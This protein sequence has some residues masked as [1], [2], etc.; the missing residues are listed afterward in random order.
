MKPR[1][2]MSI[3]SIFITTYRTFITQLPGRFL[4]LTLLS[5]MPALISPARVY[6]ESQIFNQASA[7]GE[8]TEILQCFALFILVQILYVFVYPLFRSNINYFGSEFETVL[9]NRMNQKTARIP[10]EDYETSALHK[11]ME[12]ASSGSR[13][14]RFMVMVM[15]SEILL[16]LFQFLSISG[17]LFSFHPSLALLSILSILPEIFARILNSRLRFALLDRTAPISRRKKYF[18][19]ILSAPGTLKENRILQNAGFFFGKWDSEREE[20]NREQER[21]VRKNTGISLLN[22][23]FNLVTVIL[24][25]ALI[26]WLILSDQISIGQ[27]GAALSAVATLKMNF[28]RICNLML[29]CLMDCGQNGS[30]YYRVMAHRE[31][32]GKTDVKPEV[33]NGIRVEH[34]SF[35]YPEGEEVL[36]DLSFSISPGETVAIVGENGAGK[37]TLVKVLLGLYQPASGKVSYGDTEISG[38]QEE[39]VTANNS[40]VFQDF[41]KYCLSLRENVAISQSGEPM[42]WERAEGLLREVG[43][44]GGEMSADAMLGREFGG[45][46][47][48]GGNW[49]KLAIARGLYRSHELIALDEP[50]AAIDPLLEESILNSLVQMDQGKMKLIVTHRLNTVQFADRILVLE[51]GRMAGLGTHAELLEGNPIYA[52]LWA[53]QAKWYERNQ[54]VEQ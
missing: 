48:S 50:T 34:M 49:Q 19:D 18:A 42:D 39:L 28:G 29:F 24:T 51:R 33:K 13:D 41:T 44:R 12:L 36:K 54:P 1:K 16:Y 6:L 7:L 40:A 26:I 4:L 35:R 27:F 32:N 31:R 10:L 22:Q 15:S 21:L 38:V 46:E 47:L 8:G 25:Y 2:S 52:K 45:M 43:F 53:A 23:A 5:L 9:Q 17:V 3:F 37:T 11:D 30:Y 20:Y 14:L